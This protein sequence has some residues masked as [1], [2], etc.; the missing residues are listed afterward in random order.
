[1]KLPARVSDWLFRKVE[2]P[3]SA[4]ADH[5]YLL[6]VRKGWY[7]VTDQRHRVGFG[8][9][10]TSFSG[11]WW[12]GDP[13]RV[14]AAVTAQVRMALPTGA[15]RLIPFVNHAKTASYENSPAERSPGTGK[16]TS[17]PAKGG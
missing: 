15:T 10:R 5:Q 12:S 3:E 7:A 14:A 4:V 8:Q 2:P 11:Q 17:P 6:G 13:G 1:M 9:Q 16:M